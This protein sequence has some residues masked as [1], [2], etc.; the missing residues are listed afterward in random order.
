MAGWHHRLDGCE[1]EWTLGVGDGQGGLLCRGSWGRKKLD[2]TERLNWTELMNIHSSDA[3][4]FQYLSLNECRKPIL[5]PSS[6][7]WMP[8]CKLGTWVLRATW[9]QAST[10]PR[11]SP[12]TEISI[13][14]KCSF[15]DKVRIAFFWAPRASSLSERVCFKEQSVLTLDSTD[16]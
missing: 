3:T 11:C 1:F 9:Q 2:T 15:P 10:T 7:E 8:A 4:G 16:T 13:P 5:P 12:L 6:E 14:S